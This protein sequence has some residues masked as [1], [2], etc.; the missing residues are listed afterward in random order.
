MLESPNY[1]TFLSKKINFTLANSVD[2]R[3]QHSIRV[4]N[5]VA[6]IKTNFKTSVFLNL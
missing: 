1:N 4:C 6:M 3:M 5:G 2:C